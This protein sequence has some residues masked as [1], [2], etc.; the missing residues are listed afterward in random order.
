MFATLIPI[1]IFDPNFFFARSSLLL[2]GETVVFESA[3][4]PRT[5]RRRASMLFPI[6]VQTVKVK[7]WLLIL[8][9]QRLLCLKLQPKGSGVAT[10]K[11]EFALGCA[12]SKG[13]CVVTGVES[14]SEQEF[15]IVTVCWAISPRKFFFFKFLMENFSQSLKSHPY[16]AQ[17]SDVA[18]TWIQKI[19]EA[20]GR[21][22]PQPA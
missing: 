3:V 14:K 4:E 9:T 13:R 6:H 5:L 10:V 11:S 12:P 2:P 16:S 19:N 22:L 18:S 8:T 7:T 1:S 21:P 15:V 17:S 20:L